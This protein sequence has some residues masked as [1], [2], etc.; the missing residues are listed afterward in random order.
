MGAE[1]DYIYGPPYGWLH[2]LLLIYCSRFFLF[3]FSPVGGRFLENYFLQR[4]AEDRDGSRIFSNLADSHAPDKFT[5]KDQVFTGSFAIFCAFP[6]N[7]GHFAFLY[8]LWRERRNCIWNKEQGNYVFVRLAQEFNC[9]VNFW[10]QIFSFFLVWKKR[11][12]LGESD[13]TKRRKNGDKIW[14]SIHRT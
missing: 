11:N 3:F 2:N 9:G 12:L 7:S 4:T 5:G 13:R 8:R 10:K 14:D 6:I 1:L